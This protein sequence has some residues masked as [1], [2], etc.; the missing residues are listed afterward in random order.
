MAIT[1]FVW[2]AHV[3]MYGHASLSIDGG[4]YV[5]WW[6]SGELEGKG[7]TKGNGMLGSRA[8]AS[9]MKTD[10]RSEKRIPSWASAPITCLDEDAIGQWWGQQ[11][12][13]SGTLADEKRDT[14]SNGRYN[15]LT[16]SCA[17]KVFEALVVGGLHKNPAADAIA[18]QLGLVISPN[19]IQDLAAALSGELGFWDT[20]KFAIPTDVRNAWN[21]L[22]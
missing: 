3:D 15:V 10:K 17:G 9:T 16:S 11:S 5:S 14:R 2:D 7:H 1:V 13:R 8:M 12:G 19:D 4:A 20:A 22:L 21:Y 6:P 18:G